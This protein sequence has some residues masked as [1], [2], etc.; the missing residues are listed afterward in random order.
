M[1]RTAQPEASAF[2]ICTVAAIIPAWFAARMDP[3]RALRAVL[4]LLCPGTAIQGLEVPALL[5]LGVVNFDPARLVVAPKSLIFK[6]DL[7]SR[8]GLY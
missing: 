3:V 4:G 6:D 7:G 5:T 2:V 1:A 8:P